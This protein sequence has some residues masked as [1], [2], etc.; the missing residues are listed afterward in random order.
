MREL[1][2]HFSDELY[3]VALPSGLPIFGM[4]I[5][6]RYGLSIVESLVLSVAFGAAFVALGPGSTFT[7]VAPEAEVEGSDAFPVSNC[8]VFDVSGCFGSGC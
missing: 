2:Y 8:V 7:E 6:L 5:A 1:S 3:V 4:R